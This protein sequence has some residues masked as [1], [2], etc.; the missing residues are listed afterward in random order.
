M[1]FLRAGVVVDHPSL[2]QGVAQS[3]EQIVQIAA[4]LVGPVKCDRDDVPAGYFP[5]LRLRRD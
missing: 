5:T 2:D 3:L 1:D 4:A